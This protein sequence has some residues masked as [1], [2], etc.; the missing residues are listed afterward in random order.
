MKWFVQWFLQEPETLSHFEYKG[1]LS[2]TGQGFSTD[3]IIST[4]ALVYMTFI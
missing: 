1:L 2:G 4:Y 3:S